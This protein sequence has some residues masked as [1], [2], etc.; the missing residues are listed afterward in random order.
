MSHAIMR[1]I[2]PSGH[3]Y[4]F[5]FHDQRAEMARYIYTVY[6]YVYKANILRQATDGLI[7]PLS[8]FR[9]IV[10]QSLA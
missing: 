10:E 7:Q 5:E 6:M 3:L 8:I 1:T 2:A 9:D 4:T